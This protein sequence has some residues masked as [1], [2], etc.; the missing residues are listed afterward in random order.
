V[1]VIDSPVTALLVTHSMPELLALR[2]SIQSQIKTAEVEL[3]QLDAAIA[4][5][6]GGVSPSGKERP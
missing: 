3:E 1:P 5:K 4:R 2:D 6:R